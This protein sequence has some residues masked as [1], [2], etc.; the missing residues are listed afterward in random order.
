MCPLL[1]TWLGLMLLSLIQS[2]ELEQA[3][4]E[5][6]T[7]LNIIHQR[8]SLDDPYYAQL[9]HVAINIKD[10]SWDIVKLK[11]L[12]KILQ[13]ESFVM[14]FGGSSVTAGHD[15]YYNQSYPFVFDRKLS[16]VFQHLGVELSVRNIAQGGN[17]CLPSNLC[18]DIGS[19]KPDWISWEQ[20]FNCGRAPDIFELIS[21]YAGF[22]QAIMFF[23]VSGGAGKECPPSP[24]PLPVMDESWT[25]PAS[26]RAYI[27]SQNSVHDLKETLNKHFEHG[28]SVTRFTSALGGRYPGVAAHGI[29]NFKFKNSY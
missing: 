9:M 23:M 2:R 12:L 29:I 8:F 24:D 15:N 6:Q 19:A 14:V 17:D 26:D 5:L 20:S 22:H 4:I 3:K 1:I 21:R 28:N 25:P 11:F 7:M 13:G 27:P 18:Y 10:A 16:R